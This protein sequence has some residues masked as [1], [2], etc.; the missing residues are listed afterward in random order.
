[1]TAFEALDFC[2]NIVTKEDCTLGKSRHSTGIPPAPHRYPLTST[3]LNH[4]AT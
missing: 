1:M 4:K 3:P 2:Q